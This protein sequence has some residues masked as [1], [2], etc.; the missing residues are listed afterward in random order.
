MAG[1]P[2]K[3]V[4]CVTSGVG[5]IANDVSDIGQYFSKDDARYMIPEV[6]PCL[7]QEAINSVLQNNTRERN[8]EETFD[9]RE[10]K[11]LMNLFFQKMEKDNGR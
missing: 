4:E 6:T 5:I 11:E 7:V 3:F 9:Y 8:L 10:K 2:T 1:F